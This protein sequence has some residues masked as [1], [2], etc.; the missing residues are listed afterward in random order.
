MWCPSC[1]WCYMVK[2]L[3]GHYTKELFPV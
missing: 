3:F 1:H 2:I